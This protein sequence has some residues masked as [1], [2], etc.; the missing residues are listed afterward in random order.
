MKKDYYKPLKIVHGWKQH[1]VETLEEKCSLVEQK[2]L[3][4]KEE[5]Y[6]GI[7]T[8][9]QHDSDYLDDPV[10]WKLLQKTAQL[11]E[12]YHMRMWIY[13]EKGYPSGTA[14]TKTLAA[15]PDF[16]A[17]AAV[18]MAQILSPGESWISRLPKGHEKPLSA[19]GYLMK[20]EQITD[21]EL[22]SWA[23]HPA[24]EDGFCFRN[25][26]DQN[27]LCLTFY[28]KHAYEGTHC[29]H[30]VCASRRYIDVS[31]YE[32][33]AEF[34]NNTYRPYTAALKETYAG[35]FG[36]D[37]IVDAVFTDEPSYMGHYI[38]LGLYPDGVDH[39]YD[40]TIPLYPI[41][42][43][44]VNFSNS[45]SA[46]Y[47]YRIEEEM[48]ALFLGHGERFRSVR[49]DFYQMTSD[50]YEHSFYE[51]IS[52]YCASVGLHFSGHILLEDKLSWHV[53][54]EG[55]FFK[56][57][58]Y[59]HVPG[60]DMLQSIPEN[61]WELAFTPLLVRSVAELY[62][63]RYV[64]DEVS[65]HSQGGKAGTR[66]VMISL[67]LQYAFGADVFTSYY[68]LNSN[69]QDPDMDMRA[70]LA[71][72][73]RAMSHMED[74]SYGNVILHYP[75]ETMMHLYKP[76]HDFRESDDNSDALTAE[77]ED[78][79]L[80]AMYTMINK[81]VPFLFSD[82]ESL[83]PASKRRPALFVIPAGILEEQLIR[84]LPELI[85][86]GCRIV[87]FCEK[88]GFLSEYD[89]IKAHADL[90]R[91]SGE[92]VSLLETMGQVKTAGDTTGVAALWAKNGVLLINSTTDRK[93]MCVRG[94]F[95]EV[96]NV[97][98]GQIS[99][100]NSGAQDVIPLVL[101][102]YGAMLLKK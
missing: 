17:R 3:E 93:E 91:S 75:I 64:M 33:V 41:I 83:T 87:Y 62:G 65:A 42:N 61:V 1:T 54:Y 13:D 57:L 28:Q 36:K 82:A 84:R 20:G 37:G 71:G 31:N 55:N 21:E 63:R 58:R 32:A 86:K 7:V 2:L 102:P 46:R 60:I 89:K 26:T 9:V 59:M 98:D 6:G 90:A 50:L 53:K 78:S 72:L 67:L 70:A 39:P 24:Y 29:Q 81:Q 85:E 77:C 16:E 66:Q 95:R 97:V 18:M 96:Q 76:A 10:E 8:N 68:G 88:D 5:G 49:R 23:L 45:F 92:L 22:D 73:E 40:D 74:I 25:E 12:K 69:I 94:I 19:F 30:N 38:N 51:Q 52:N 101:E 11:C 34:I 100:G 15:N 48:T 99:E 4:I 43:W 79:M 44:G 35:K 14:G 27:M 56:L 47:G 80:S